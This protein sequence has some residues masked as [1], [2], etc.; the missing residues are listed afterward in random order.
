MRILL[1]I[2]LN[3]ALL[4]ASAWAQTEFGQTTS[5][6]PDLFPSRRAAAASVAGRLGELLSN[7]TNLTADSRLLVG[8]AE[9][10]EH[11]QSS[12]QQR[13][14]LGIIGAS[15][16]EGFADGTGATEPVTRS[17]RAHA[18]RPAAGRSRP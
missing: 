16:R 4:S 17:E 5:N 18:T 11:G 14:V 7:D 13:N 9:A 6:G 2:I 15:A 8:A 1:L 10:G 12:K 3:I